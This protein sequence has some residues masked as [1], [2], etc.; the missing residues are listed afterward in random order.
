MKWLAAC[1]LLLVSFSLDA[2]TYNV[3]VEPEPGEALGRA[4][5]RLWIPDDVPKLRGLI[6]RQHGCGEGARKLGREHADDPQWQALARKWDCALLGSQLWAPE[7]DCSTWT[8]PQDGSARAFLSGLE[9][10]AARSN[11]PELTQVPWCLWGHSGGAM[12]VCNMTYRYPERVIA[13]FPRSGG[14]APVGRTFSRSQPSGFEDSPAALEVP[15]L[16]CFGER[17]DV[18]GT[19]FFAGTAAARQLFEYGRSRHA[20]WSLAVHPGSEHENGN[21]RLLAIRFFDACLKQRLPA[22]SAANEN[23]AALV[24]VSRETSWLGDLGS[25]KI[26][27]ERDQPRE[28]ATMAWL[29]NSAT[30]RAWQEFSR[31]G[32]ISDTTPPPAPERVLYEETDDGIKLSWTA[33]ADVESGIGSFRVYRDGTMIGEVRGREDARWNPHRHYHSWN[34]SDQPLW[35]TEFPAKEFLDT[36]VTSIREVSYEVSTVNQ[37][38]LESAKSAAIPK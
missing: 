27:R 6:V 32:S 23:P 10:L 11:H 36:R 34:Y 31:R 18:E 2:A 21:S 3:S 38:G 14:L 37:A 28:S 24:A 5:Y 25:L 1:G 22:E 7:E 26:F 20:P 35:G 4:D 16:F 33:R 19:R 13:A 9:E 29:P 17:E 8:I 30:A 15:I 12:W